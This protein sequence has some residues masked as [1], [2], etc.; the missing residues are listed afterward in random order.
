VY[1]PSRKTPQTAEICDSAFL[2]PT[3]P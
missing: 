1:N 2:R 3:S